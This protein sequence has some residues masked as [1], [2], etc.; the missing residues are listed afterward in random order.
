MGEQGLRKD[1]SRKGEKGLRKDESRKWQEGL[2]NAGKDDGK[3]F[4]G[5]G[6]VDK[7]KGE[8]EAQSM[9]MGSRKSSEGLGGVG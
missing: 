6:M 5:L 3:G 2:R 8:L 1:E 9:V 4:S 7:G